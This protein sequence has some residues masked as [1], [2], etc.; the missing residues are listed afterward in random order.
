M[1]TYF[2][3]PTLAQGDQYIREG[4]CMQKASSWATAWPPITLATMAAIAKRNGVVRFLDGN[5]EPVT[6][7]CL[8]DDVKL[9]APDLVVINTGF[10]SINNDME[11][12]QKIKEVLPNTKLL[13]FGVYFTL[14][15]KEAL[16]NHPF[17]DFGIVG[18]P[19]ET[20]EELLNALSENRTNYSQIKGLLYREDFRVE[21]TPARP[22]MQNLDQL[23]FPDRSLL[24]NDR[25]RLPHNNKVYTLINVARGC[26]YPCT[27]CIVNPYFG[28]MVRKHSVDY[29]IKEIKEC[30]NQYGVEEF[31]FWEEV[32]TLDRNYALAIC[33]AILSNHLTIK[34]AATTRVGLLDEEL[35]QAMKKSGCYLLGLGIESGSQTILDNAKKKQTVDEIKQA[36]QLCKRVGIKTM[37][38]FIFGLPGETKKTATETIKFMKSLGLNYMQSYCAVP[39]PK[40]EFG[41]LAKSKGWVRADRWSQYDFGGRSIVDSG[42]IKPE[43]VTHFRRKAFRSFYFRPGYLLNNVLKELPISQILRLFNFTD[44]M[45]SKRK[46]VKS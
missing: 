36:V 33:N 6:L 44:W 31:L 38:H 1:K 12:A 7:P 42:T 39:Y 4:R 18:E 13:G 14:L 45:N 32:F 28:R 8:L 25:Y 19:E 34:W 35:L 10:P 41:E 5:V 40:T 3:N 27:Y 15:E 43:E 2:L 22:F 16:T 37:G 21:V 23:P 26:P 11:V 46:K 17:L 29:V 9:N 30:I 24:K 20:F